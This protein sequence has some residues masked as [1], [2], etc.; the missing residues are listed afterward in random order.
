AA[1]HAEVCEKGWDEKRRTFVQYYGGET[2]DAGLLFMPLS[3][4]LPV[5]DPRIKGTIRAIERELMVDGFLQRYSAGPEVDG[6]PPGE[7]A[8]LA[9]SFWLCDVYRLGG[10]A[11]QATGLF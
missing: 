2:L 1:I 9:C 7:G 4:F 3:G 11:F 5:D 10:P 8:F 6:L